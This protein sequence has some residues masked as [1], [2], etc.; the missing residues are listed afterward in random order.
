MPAWDLEKISILI[1]IFR[2]RFFDFD[3]SILNF[4][5]RSSYLTARS[6]FFFQILWFQY[7]NFEKKYLLFYCSMGH[8]LIVSYLEFFWIFFFK[9]FFSNLYLLPIAAASTMSLPHRVFFL[10]LFAQ[11]LG[12]LEKISQELKKKKLRAV[13]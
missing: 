11:L 12:N 9:L 7:S 13:K 10:P 1:L 8:A 4:R 5:F 6:F 3:F 2:F